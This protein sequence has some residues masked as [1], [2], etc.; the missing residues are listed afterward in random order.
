MCWYVHDYLRVIFGMHKSSGVL[1][2][3]VK[4]KAKENFCMVS[5]LLF[6]IV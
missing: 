5:M 6:C 4:L 2:I 1:L 3:A